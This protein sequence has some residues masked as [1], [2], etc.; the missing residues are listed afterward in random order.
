MSRPDLSEE[1]VS[2]QPNMEVKSSVMRVKL[3]PVLFL[4]SLT[5][6]LFIFSPE[7]FCR[8]TENSDSSWH[9]V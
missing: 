9:F 7:H 4:R 3:L 5:T 8:K 1:R 2:I 6:E